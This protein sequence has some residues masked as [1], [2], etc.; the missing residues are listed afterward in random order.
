MTI[1]PW[2]LASSE[3]PL[4]SAVVTITGS[5]S[6]VS[7]TAT[8]TANGSVSRPR[9]RSAALAMRTRG[10]VS[11]MKRISVQE[12]PCTERSKALVPR[13]RAE[14]SYAA[15]NLVSA[16]VAVTTAVP[17]PEA[18]LLPWKHSSGRANGPSPAPHPG[19]AARSRAGVSTGCFVTGTDSPVSADW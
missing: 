9:P 2:F 16:P 15:A 18:T 6:G 14:L 8:A 7:P 4:A 19:P 3:A 5:I 13:R 17:L 11:S 1:T 12:I 10:G